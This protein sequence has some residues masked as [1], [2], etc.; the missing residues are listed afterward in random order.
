MAT[1]HVNPGAARNIQ[2]RPVRGE[3]D[4]FRQLTKKHPAAIHRC[5]KGGREVVA[6]HRRG[7]GLGIV[8]PPIRRL[9]GAQNLQ[10]IQR[11]R[12]ILHRNVI[13]RE[14]PWG[15]RDEMFA[16]A[17]GEMK[18]T[19]CSGAKTHR[20]EQSQHHVGR[21]GIDRELRA[22][23]AERSRMV[24]EPGEEIEMG[25]RSIDRRDAIAIPVK[26]QR[27][28]AG[29]RGSIA[30]KSVICGRWKCEC[31]PGGACGG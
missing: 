22:N 6:L 19:T 24:R 14:I 4:A 26:R 25:D 12:P 3:I 16:R 27:I 17:Q 21:S 13:R 8:A 1:T 10:H 28:V 30:G 29:E 23:R 20:R 9:A 11:L 2:Q 18:A 15:S 31:Q 5:G 7:P